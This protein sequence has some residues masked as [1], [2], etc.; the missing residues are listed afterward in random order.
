METQSEKKLEELKKEIEEEKNNEHSTIEITL[1]NGEMVTVQPPE[2]LQENKI[3]SMGEKILHPSLDIRDNFLVLGFRYR[4]SVEE[5]K[6]VF[7][8]MRDRAIM[9]TDKDIIV[10]KN[11]EDENDT[12]ETYFLELQKRKL[13]WIED[14]WSMD[15]LQKFVEN[16]TIANNTIPNPKEMANKITGLAKKYIELEKEI[17]YHLLS[18]W[19]AG[20]YFFPIFYAYPFLNIKAPKGSGKSQ[21]LNF[22]RQVCFNALKSRPTM[23][24]LGDTVDAL[25]GT[26]LIDQADS[27]NPKDNSGLLD[28]LADSYKKG[29]GKRRI[30]NVNKGRREILEFETYSPKVFASIKELP[31]DLRDRCLVIPLI[32]S[33]KN[34]HDPDDDN[35]NWREI[36]GM[37]YKFL[38]NNYGEVG[39]LYTVGKSE[40]RENNDIVGRKLELWL[41]IET[42]F[43]LFGWADEIEGAKERFLAWYGFAEYEPSEIEEA[44][45]IAVIEQF[46][47]KDMIE[48][49]PKEIAQYID[50]T[51][52]VKIFSDAKN[53]KHKAN[54]VGRAIKN[55]NLSSEK[56]HT[57]NGNR[58]LFEKSKVE[59][60]Y[61]SY[62]SKSITPPTPEQQSVSEGTLF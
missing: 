27:I 16:F 2:K 11:D 41:P 7:L 22:L 42:I 61:A 35:E 48:L 4:A 20:T 37:I 58:Y 24:A 57:K 32:R 53:D 62:F 45:A 34:F 52:D 17:D 38:V 31:E 6:N 36:R 1:P 40:S 46:E 56:R 8:I 13:M 25:R 26:Y 18:A 39:S 51:S 54:M 23:A 12:T 15:A 3:E 59:T 33:Q 9:L 47:G 30:M 28:L 55:F 19:I 29:G 21:C 14:R 49:S 50:Y 60:I 43:K 10:I 44:V 5:E